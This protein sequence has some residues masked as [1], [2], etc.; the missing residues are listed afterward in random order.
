MAYKAKDV[1]RP[2]VRANRESC[3]KYLDRVKRLYSLERLRWQ[4]CKKKGLRRSK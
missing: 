4:G 2:D 3:E 1:K